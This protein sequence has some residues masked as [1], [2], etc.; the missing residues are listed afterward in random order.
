MKGRRLAALLCV[1]LSHALVIIPLL[2]L[3]REQPREPV[4]EF[5]G[6]PITFSIQE[7]ALGETPPAQF[8]PDLAPVPFAP[9]EPAVGQVASG[10]ESSQRTD[11]SGVD[12]PLER[13]WSWAVGAPMT[14]LRRRCI[15]TSRCMPELL[16]GRVIKLPSWRWPSPR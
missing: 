15:V 4:P 6:A 10:D 7:P 5:D 13:C 3:R 1:L 16:A 12:W 8:S 2:E 11:T 9:R 14:R